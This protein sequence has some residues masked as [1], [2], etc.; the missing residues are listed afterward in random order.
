M[1]N[2]AAQ[3]DAMVVAAIEPDAAVVGNVATRAAR[4]RSADVIG[5]AFEIVQAPLALVVRVAGAARAR[6]VALAAGHAREIGGAVLIHRTVV[7]ASE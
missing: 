1:P 5:A 2:V 4:S 6:G 3:I 7:A